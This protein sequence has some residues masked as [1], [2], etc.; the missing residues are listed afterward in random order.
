[1]FL[2][3]SALS[4]A[5]SV[6]IFGN[7]ILHMAGTGAAGAALIGGVIAAIAIFLYAELGAAFPQAGGVYPGLVGVLGRFWAFPYITMMMVLSPTL[8][9]FISLGF[10]DY[11][12]TLAPGLPQIPLAI[13][14]LALA[15]L[16]AV[17]PIRASAIVTAVFLSIEVA[18][19]VILVV[20]ALTH[21][22]R[23]LGEALSHPMVLEHGQMQ[24]LSFA[25][26]GLAV[27]TGVF[28]TAGGSWAMYF[29]EELKDSER[30]IGPV[31]AWAG[32]LAALTIAGPL[33]LMVLSVTDLKGVLGSDSPMAAYIAQTGGPMIGAI[34]NGGLVIAFFNAMVASVMGYGR[35][36]Y[37]TGRD[38]TWPGPV[39]R[40]LG[41]VH[42]KL[43][44][45][46]AATIVL[47]AFAIAMMFLGEQPLLILSSGENVFEFLLIAIAVLVGR[48]MGVTGR[49]F[50]AL[51]HPLV[52]LLALAATAAFVAAQWLDEAAGRPSLFFLGG[53]FVLSLVYHRLRI[54]RPA[55]VAPAPV[56][57]TAS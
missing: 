44:S 34:V 19:L 47:V 25:G 17:M 45:P 42:P 38:G 41:Q 32:Q 46:V 4:P 43:K 33:I 28:T 22:A 1:M 37:A 18:A 8:M 39:N 9:A 50:R 36:Y 16:V 13:G 52:P 21:P 24:S 15:A 53:L 10:A 5:V 2:T 30:R 14:C 23:S 11:V 31:I 51:L 40:L 29:G 3:L 49:H 35:L 54:R 12:R 48:R 6:F 56:A 57:D 7:G 27:V 20:V 26:L 55:G